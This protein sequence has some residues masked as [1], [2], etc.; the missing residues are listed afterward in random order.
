MQ[1][2]YDQVKKT[3]Q[4]GA[5]VSAAA[6]LAGFFFV[7][8]LIFAVATVIATAVIAATLSSRGTHRWAWTWVAGIASVVWVSSAIYA[9][10]IWGLAFNLRDANKPVPHALNIVMVT[11]FSLSV[12]AFLAVIL[13]A[14]VSFFRA[15]HLKPRTSVHAAN[16]IAGA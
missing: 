9:I 6:L 5:G 2:S 4:I 15:R 3:L 1:T 16:I 7:P 10:D 11:A 14:A 12:A 13:S 8:F